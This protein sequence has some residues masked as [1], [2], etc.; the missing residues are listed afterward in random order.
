MD[1]QRA[2]GTVVTTQRKSIS[3]SEVLALILADL[4]SLEK[5][6]RRFT[7]YFSLVPLYNAGLGDDELQTYRNAL[8]KLA[9]SLSWHP[10]I[11]VPKAID[12]NKVILRI[13]LR[14]FQWDA[15]LWNRILAE[16]PYG[17]LHDTA[18]ARACPSRRPRGCR[19]SARTGSSPPPR[20]RRCIATSSNCR[21][22][23]PS[24]SGSCAWMPQ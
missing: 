8:S 14:D 5:R 10:R 13:D 21:P 15:N 23:L 1:R 2:P 24:W 7:R 3:E 17:L 6:S 9:N 22:T 18:V 12:P 4:E 19:W 20:G 16:Y 11:T